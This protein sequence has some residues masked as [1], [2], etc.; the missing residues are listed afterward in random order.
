MLIAIPLLSL[1]LA[2]AAGAKTVAVTITKNGYVPSAVT[3][4]ARINGIWMARS[5]EED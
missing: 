2:G 1:A 5:P 3:V 4:G